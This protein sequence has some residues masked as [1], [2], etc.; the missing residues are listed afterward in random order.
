MPTLCRNVTSA[1]YATDGGETFGAI[2]GV[3][4]QSNREKSLKHAWNLFGTLKREMKKCRSIVS[5]DKHPSNRASNIIT[6]T[7]LNMQT[8][9][10]ISIQGRSSECGGRRV[11]EVQLLY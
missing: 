4:N 2:Y 9:Y 5:Y 7:T 10:K 6:G 8:V 3:E 11:S 1:T